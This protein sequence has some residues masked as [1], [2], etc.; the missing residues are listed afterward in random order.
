[1][2][3]NQLV[4]PS[5]SILRVKVE[6][7]TRDQERQ[8]YEDADDY[9]VDSPAVFVLLMLF[10]LTPLSFPSLLVPEGWVVRILHN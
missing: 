2:A 6:L 5:P 4:V 1:M 3:G 10:L 7:D 8:W 9:Q